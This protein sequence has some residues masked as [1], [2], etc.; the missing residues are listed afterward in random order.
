MAGFLL[1]ITFLL[2]GDLIPAHNF[3]CH[4]AF[5]DSPMCVASPDLSSELQTYTFHHLIDTYTQVAQR[6]VKCNRT[7]SWSLPVAKLC[8]VLLH[9]ART[10]KLPESSLIPLTDDQDLWALPNNLVTV[11]LSLH[12]SRNHP[13]PSYRHLSPGSCGD[14]HW[15]TLATPSILS[16]YCS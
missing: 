12:P 11:R 15:S 13:S 3:S 9:L 10:P 1:F 5:D 8:I 4:L 7:F 14:L 16:P 2:P 6:H